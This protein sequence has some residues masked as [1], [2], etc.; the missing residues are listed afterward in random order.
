M[1]S[2]L[3]HLTQDQAQAGDLAQETF[4]RVFDKL[5]TFRGEASLRTWIYR[6]ATNAS[7]DHFRSLVALQ[8]KVK[9]SFNEDLLIFENYR[10]P[11]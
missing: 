3:L 5:K 10:V 4:I 6:I 2:Y 7:I 1:H 11:H 8:D 9:Q